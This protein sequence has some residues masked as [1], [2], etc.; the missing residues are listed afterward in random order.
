MWLHISFLIFCGSLI[1]YIIL[2]PPELVLRLV[3]KIPFPAEV[4]LCSQSEYQRI[5]RNGI[6]LMN[7]IQRWGGKENWESWVDCH[8]QMS[9]MSPD[10]ASRRW[11]ADDNKI[12]LLN[13][14][15]VQ[16][17][18]MVFST[19]VFE[20]MSPSIMCAEMSSAISVCG[21]LTIHKCVWES[22]HP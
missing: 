8:E 15:M 3:T 6:L 4:V 11:T 9:Q 10:V 19:K 18:Y 17:Y 16:I 12:K 14:T 20:K 21:N 7:L 22:H 5:T 1:G 13:T 2:L